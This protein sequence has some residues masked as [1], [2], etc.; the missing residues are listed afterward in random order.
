MIPEGLVLDARTVSGHFPGIGRVVLGLAG[1][2]SRL[3]SATLLHAAHPDPRLPVPPL[4]GVPCGAGPFALRQQW[5]VPRLLRKAGARVYHS[6]YY[7]MPYRPGIP[8]VVTCF[9]LIPMLTPGAFGR[10]RRIA[11]VLA[12]RLAFRASAI[13]CVPSEATRRDV[14]RLFPAARG[15]LTI[16]RPGVTWGQA[17]PGQAADRPTP[18]SGA[19]PA[20]QW[21]CPRSVLPPRFLLQVGSNKPHKGLDVLLR[22]WALALAEAPA[23]TAGITLVMAGPRVLNLDGTWASWMGHWATVAVLTVL[24]VIELVSD[25]MES[26][27]SRKTAPQFLARLV[28]GAFAGAVLGTTWGYKWSSLGAGMIGAVLGTI[29]GYAARTRLVAANGGND[30]PIAIGEDVFAAGLGVAVAYLTSTL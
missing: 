12:H 11:Y 17:P 23:Q 24:A 16:V 6:P 20:A 3:G 19:L 27:P 22:A 7:L 4:A 26:M 25:Q 29:G 13:V 8:T 9:D 30:R 1:A 10:G 5:E 21:G 28:T 18:A 2:L 14:E 15:K